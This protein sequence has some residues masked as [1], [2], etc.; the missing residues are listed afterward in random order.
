MAK[1]PVAQFAAPPAQ[2]RLARATL[3]GPERSDTV[4]RAAYVDN[5]PLLVMASWTPPRPSFI[6]RAFLQQS[7]S[8]FG[9][10]VGD[11]YARPLQD[12]WTP[13][14]MPEL[15]DGPVRTGVSLTGPSNN[16]GMGAGVQ[17]S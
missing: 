2:T 1:A 13:A 7:S 17:P 14:P 15:F 12:G 16:S 10:L 5:A 6:D 9:R 11:S 4:E 8:E 3:I